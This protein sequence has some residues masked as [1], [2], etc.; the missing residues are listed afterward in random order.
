MLPFPVSISA[1]YRSET[2]ELR[3]S[4]FRV[5]PQPARAWRTLSAS[6]FKG[7]LGLC[8]GR[9]LLPLRESWD[10]GVFLSIGLANYR[11]Q[12]SQ[13]L[14]SKL[15]LQDDL[16]DL[17]PKCIIM[18]F[19]RIDS[20]SSMQYGV[21]SVGLVANFYTSGPKHANCYREAGARLFRFR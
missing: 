2:P 6:N 14:R 12:N 1:R 17:T 8:F 20:T 9:A 19:S 7:S 16:R 11:R 10:R 21:I 18:H 4:I 15:S 13:Q 3:A 5:M